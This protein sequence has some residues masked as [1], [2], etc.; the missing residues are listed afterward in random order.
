MI[1]GDNLTG[2]TKVSFNGISAAF[3]VDSDTEITATVPAGAA[4]GMIEVTTPSGTLYS[5][6]AFVVTP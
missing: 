2:T 1:L 4:T 6:A 5:N 3:T